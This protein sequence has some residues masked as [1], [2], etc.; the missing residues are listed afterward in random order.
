M[1][2]KRALS[3]LA[4][5]LTAASLATTA[6]SPAASAAS[7]VHCD[8]NTNYTWYWFDCTSSNGAQT[9]WY[10]NGVRQTQGAGTSYYS[11]SCTYGR[12]YTISVNTGTSLAASWRG[13][14]YEDWWRQTSAS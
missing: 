9:I 4:A 3:T 11:W 2:A 8:T 10:I 13:H 6:Y 12:W 14:C 7:T 5:T 1:K